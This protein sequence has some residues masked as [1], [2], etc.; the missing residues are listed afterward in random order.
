MLLVA[1]AVAS[2]KLPCLKALQMLAKRVP[3]QRRPIHSR[4]SGRSV[5]SA[6]QRRIQYNLDGFHTVE[7]NPQSN[8]QSTGKIRLTGLDESG[9]LRGRRD[10][11]ASRHNDAQDSR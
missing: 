11:V 10:Y 3:N 6:E 2:L 8:Q 4:P 1:P 7:Y 5:C 9:I